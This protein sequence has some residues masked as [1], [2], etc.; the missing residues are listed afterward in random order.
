ML[1]LKFTLD[2]QDLQMNIFIDYFL[3]ETIDDE[4]E[5]DKL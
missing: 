2:Y 1:H 5:I 3:L 4:E